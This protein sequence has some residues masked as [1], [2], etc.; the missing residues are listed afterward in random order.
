MSDGKIQTSELR[1]F[2]EALRALG[3]TDAERAQQLGISPRT[4]VEY[5]AGRLPVGVRSLWRRPEVLLALAADAE[6][7]A[8][9]GSQPPCAAAASA[10]TTTE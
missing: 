7:A 1:H 8:P 3:A 4:F 2:T 9:R 10:E 6:L 5:K